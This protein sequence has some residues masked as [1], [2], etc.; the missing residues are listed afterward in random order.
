[1]KEEM[2]YEDPEFE[3]LEEDDEPI[4]W[5]GMFVKIWNGKKFIII[6]T[7]IFSVLGVA[8]ALGMK[9]KYTASVTLAPEVGTSGS[10]GASSL[11]SIA[12]MFGMG[13]MLSG[14]SSA[15]ALNITLF[16]EMASSTP[17][18]TDLFDLKVKP[19]VSK[20][21]LEKGVPEM[22]E[23]TLYRWI[24]KKDAPKGF[25]AKI[26]ESI[27]GAVEEEETTV[28]NPRQLTKEQDKAVRLLKKA[29]SADVDKKTGITS[30]SVTI[31][32]PVMAAQI[33]DTVCQRLQDKIFKYRTQKSAADLE[34]YTKLSAEA[35]E[36]MIKAQAAYAISVDF[37]RSV[38]LQSV[39]SEKE[40]LQQEAMLAEQIY[41]Q[42]E[43]QKEL[44]KAKYQES[45][46]VFAI[47]E[48]ASVPLKPSSTSRLVIVIM[49]MFLG[50]A[51]SVAW[52]LFV[53]DFAKDFMTSIK[54][55]LKEEKA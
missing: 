11:K 36:K 16:P 33:A 26:K 21:D 52:K 22:P 38:I 34:Y 47:V 50:G 1:M 12:S 43:Q 17:F 4:D 46:P 54:E 8:V 23:T 31:D 51:G 27:F 35:K 48:P 10:G 2:T 37:D 18:I 44:A 20:K 3:Y 45:K 28:V 29:I 25:I 55:K 41:Q 40:R 14:G 19:Y 32:D 9:K 13:G 53:E 42:M 6:C 39:S 49:F 5:A 30:V 24:L 15:D 7:I